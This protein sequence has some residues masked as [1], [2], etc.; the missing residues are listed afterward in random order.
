MLA[1][2]S[3][4]RAEPSWNSAGQA[5]LRLAWRSRWAGHVLSVRLSKTF[6]RTV[7]WPRRAPLTR[8]PGSIR[9]PRGPPR[10]R[11]T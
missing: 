10:R 11:A 7:P 9:P 1:I 3:N 2:R 4:E 5:G 6:M 8:C